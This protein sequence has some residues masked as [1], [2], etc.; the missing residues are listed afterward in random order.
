MMFENYPWPLNKDAVIDK[1]QAGL[2]VSLAIE[3]D[4]EPEPKN[5]QLEA[6]TKN[7][8]RPHGTQAACLYK[9]G[10]N[11]S[12]K[13]YRAFCDRLW[14]RCSGR[15]KFLFFLSCLEPAVRYM[16]LLTEA[17][18]VLYDP[19]H[20]VHQAWIKTH[21]SFTTA[22]SNLRKLKEAAILDTVIG[23]EEATRVKPASTDD[24][25]PKPKYF[26]SV[27]DEDFHEAMD[28][29][30]KEDLPLVT[31][32]TAIPVTAE[33]L[34]SYFKDPPTIPEADFDAE[35]LQEVLGLIEP[36][37]PHALL[38]PIMAGVPPYPAV[39]SKQL[40]VFLN[41]RLLRALGP[42]QYFVNVLDVLSDTYGRHFGV[43]KSKFNAAVDAYIGK[44]GDVDPTQLQV[45]L[46]DNIN[47]LS[48][49]C[50][51][52]LQLHMICTNCHEKARATL[53]QIR[54][55]REYERAENEPYEEACFTPGCINSYRRLMPLC[56]VCQ[57]GYYV[58]AK[59]ATER[60]Q[61]IVRAKKEEIER[62]KAQGEKD[63]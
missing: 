34:E 21:I 27:S 39:I 9:I 31:Q 32:H 16:S 56:S 49:G 3:V 50:P 28:S 62:L 37:D 33:L 48:P 15:V 36:I 41:M 17:I 7:S 55:A 30:P 57:G 12:A 43:N 26:R 58:R 44:D 38:N 45:A 59:Q 60:L 53:T 40:W 61:E 54:K 51:G 23:E 6:P 2:L 20:E 8:H 10:T 22:G 47:C 52:R 25:S 1:E 63:E 5:L 11:V 29:I 35:N 42:E 4:K 46:L 14:E 18:S 24:A 19:S 13:E